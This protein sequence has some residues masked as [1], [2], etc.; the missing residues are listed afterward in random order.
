MKKNITMI[1]AVL[2]LATAFTACHDE[3][4]GLEG[5]GTVYLTTKI[6]SDVKVQSRG[7]VTEYA[8]NCLIYISN[9]KGLVRRFKGISE[10]PA[11]GIQLVSDHYIA[12]GWAGD[13]VSASFD[14]KWFKGRTE[15][16]VTNGATTKVDL[17]CS[18]ANV[19]ASVNYAAEVGEILTE[20]K[21]TVGH[22]KG[23][24]DFAADEKR[25][26]YFMMPSKDKDLKWTFSGKLANG[27][28]YTREG[29]IKDAKPATQYILNVKYTGKDDPIGGGYFVIEIDERAV[30]VNDV[31]VITLAPEIEGYDFDISQPVAG[32]PGNVK[33][34]S[35]YITAAGALTGLQ[36]S[37][38]IIGGISGV[39]GS[40]VDLFKMSDAIKQ[41]LN[42]GGIN[43]NYN[44]DADEDVSWI[45][46]NFETSLLNTLKEGEYAVNITATD[47]NGET[48]TGTLNF[49]ITSAP[50][51]AAATVATEVW[52]TT[53]TIYGNILKEGATTPTLVYRAKGAAAWTTAA[54]TTEG[55]KLTAALTGLTPGTTY[56][57]AAQSGEYTSAVM[58]FT[59]EAAQ[60]LVNG[61]FEGWTTTKAPYLMY[62]EGQ[63]M[64]WDSGNHGSATMS[65]NITTPDG[66]VKVEGNYSAK[67]AS[68]FVGVGAIGKF[69]AGNA[70]VGKYIAT[71]GTDGV[72]GWGRS[73]GSRPK[74]LK[75]YIKYAPGTIQYI[76][77]GAPSSIAK[78]DPDTGII[79][80]ALL[81]NHTETYSSK[82]GSGTYPVI[83]KTKKSERQLFDKSASNVIAYGEKVFTEATAGNGMIEFEIPLTYFKTDVKVSNIMIVCSASRYGDFFTGGVSTMWIDN[84]QLVY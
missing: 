67:L 13:S 5:Q 69:A 6:N 53:A 50:V 25:A 82:N 2:V 26:G 10:V 52:P 1:G 43:Y 34:T 20:Y 74:A 47:A 60:Q 30:E 46:I 12:E 64:W 16:D 3:L 24:L 44:Y 77:D 38:P 59:T 35:L 36:L 39:G 51:A 27:D 18:I 21:M 58:T 72:L 68:Q 42:A 48:S 70:F 22:S 79:Y 29:V 7:D 73:F 15:F 81:T 8:D 66:D 11:D 37:S 9:K 40:D 84:F 76:G 57:Y 62:A 32:E 63:E 23:T 31:I 80:I 49:N 45:K 75:G 65:K 83:V 28:T 56:E 14:H 55:T 71:E 4:G 33:R 54:T 78:G 19:L 61:G 41:A 17:T